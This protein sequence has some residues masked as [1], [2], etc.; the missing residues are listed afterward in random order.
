LR[1]LSRVEKAA[2]NLAL[3]FL[4]FTLPAT[5]LVVASDLGSANS[6][7]LDCH[8]EY[9]DGLKKTVHRVVP[10]AVG[11]K[12]PQVFCTSCHGDAS[13][14]LEEPSAENI[15]NPAR[16]SVFDL[17]KTCAACH[18]S[19]HARQ[20]TENNVHFREGVGCLDCHSIH[21]PRA[22]ARLVRPSVPLC[23]SCHLEIKQKLANPF[24]HPIN[25]KVMKCIDCHQILKEPGKTF[26]MARQDD[27]CFDCHQEFQGPFIHEHDAANDYSL[28]KA[29]CMSCHDPHGSV[30]P[31]LLLQPGRLL[32]QQ[33]HLLPGHL[34]AHNG[35]YATKNCLDCHTDIHGSYTDERFFNGGILAD[36]C[37]SVSCHAK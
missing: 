3:L 24:R 31:R 8:S 13:R 21:Q 37:F 32:C 9:A 26:S 36:N 18:Q 12:L 11:S 17:V 14:H 35:I 34:T 19:E 5:R 28:E 15:I 1:T 7:C 16:S 4:I 2:T 33:C 20:F 30:N 27:A 29:G 23:L 25:D 6:A 10:E 22:E